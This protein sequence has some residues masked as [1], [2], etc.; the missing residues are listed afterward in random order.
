MP[1]TSRTVAAPTPIRLGPIDDQ[2]PA[3][4]R[5]IEIAGLGGARPAQT[6]AG[7]RRTP[8][9][10]PCRGSM[11]E[12]V[13]SARPAASGCRVEGAR[14]RR[15]QAAPR[16]PARRQSASR[17]SRT[18]DARRRHRVPSDRPH[19]ES[20]ARTGPARQEPSPRPRRF[21]TAPSRIDRPHAPGKARSLAIRHTE[22]QSTK[23]RD[24]RP[25]APRPTNTRPQLSPSRRIAFARCSYSA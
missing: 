5:R 17:A 9:P 10:V 12:V 8:R 1:R 4:T 20:I 14:G 6:S 25:G 22:A 11:L 2:S 18:G 3:C 16:L 21:G 23:P 7:A 15:L 19:R 13:S 24:Q